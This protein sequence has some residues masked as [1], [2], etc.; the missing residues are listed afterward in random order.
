MGNLSTCHLVSFVF[1]C[2]VGQPIRLIS[3]PLHRYPDPRAPLDCLY[4]LALRPFLF[5][6][7]LP[8]EAGRQ[9][10]AASREHRVARGADARPGKCRSLQSCCISRLKSERKK[11][12]N[13]PKPPA[14][15]SQPYCHPWGRDRGQRATVA[16]RPINGTIGRAIILIKMVTRQKC[17]YDDVLR[18]SLFTSFVTNAHP[19]RPHRVVV[20]LIFHL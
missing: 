2:R 19:S 1:F 15:V 12:A 5:D 7:N 18:I 11:K 16:T 17:R 20:Q 13:L 9:L 3:Q 4:L 8:G 10:L 6:N 14:I